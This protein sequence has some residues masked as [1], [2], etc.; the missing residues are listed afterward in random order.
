MSRERADPGRWFGKAAAIMRGNLALAGSAFVMMT[1]I[2]VAGD[3]GP[4]ASSAVSL[5]LL[6][7]QLLFQY[8]LTLAALAKLGLAERQGRRRLWALLGLGILGGLGILL[9]VVLLILPGLYLYVRWSLAT[10]ILIAEGA[11][12]VEALTRSGQEVS[13][14][15]WPVAGLFLLVGLPWLA[16]TSMEILLAPLTLLSSLLSNGLAYLSIIMAWCAA[17]AV[18]RD[19]RK[20]ERLEEVFS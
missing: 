11:G 3:L 5:F 17:I 4:L 10:P 12:P 15:F 9:G 14:R 20:D 16:G 18:Y 7:V 19:G 6:P 8:E 13:G 1:A 2:G